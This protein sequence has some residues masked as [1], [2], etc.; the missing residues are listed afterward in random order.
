MNQHRYRANVAA[1]PADLDHELDDA[2][3]GG[4]KKPLILVIAL[5]I[6]AVAG[7]IVFAKVN[8]YQATDTGTSANDF[9]YTEAVDP[10]AAEPAATEPVGVV[11]APQPEPAAPARPMTHTVDRGGQMLQSVARQYNVDLQDLARLNNLDSNGILRPGTI[12][13]LPRDAN[14]AAPD[15]AANQD[16]REL[17]SNAPRARPTSTPAELDGVPVMRAEPVGAASTTTPKPSPN[18]GKSYT[19]KAGDT[20]TKIAGKNGT[21]VEALKKANNISDPTKIRVGQSL[22]IP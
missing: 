15:P 20:L 14:L 17:M 10:A 6:I 22:K 9:R 1:D 19:I 16:V 7:L 4:I 18:S 3:E 13:R 21:T 12:L 8:T 5:H 2:H 11:V